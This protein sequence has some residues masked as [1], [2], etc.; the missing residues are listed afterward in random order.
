MP[1]RNGPRS[2]RGR[3]AV[4]RRVMFG[5]A[6]PTNG[7]MPSIMVL[8]FGETKPIRTTYFGGPIKGGSAPSV[9]WS[10]ATP[11][12]IAANGGKTNFLFKFKTSY[13]PRPFGPYIVS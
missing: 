13:G 5:G 3:S 7:I 8:P 6:T 2:T 10:T 12:K 11:Y 1:Q 9:G 4:A